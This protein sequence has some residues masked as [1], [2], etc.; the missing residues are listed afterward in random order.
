MII[1]VNSSSLNGV[2]QEVRKLHPFR[3]RASDSIPRSI[4]DEIREK[5]EACPFESLSKLAFTFGVREILACLEILVSNR[6][7]ELGQKAARVL[8]LRPRKQVILRGWFRLVSSYPHD[9]LEATLRELIENKG[10]DILK[11][12]DKVSTQAPYWLVSA[13]LAEGVFREYQNTGE[14]QILDKYLSENLIKS[15]EGL[16]RVVWRQLLT[17][18]SAKSLMKE[19][20]ERILQK[21]SE[22]DNASHVPSFGQHYLN[23]LKSRET[24]DETILDFIEKKFG[25]PLDGPIETPFWQEVSKLAKQDFRTWLILRRIEDFFEGERGDFWRP[26]VEHNRVRRVKEILNRD[27][28]LLDFGAFGVVEFKNVGNAAYIYPRVEF[29]AFW[30]TRPTWN[31]P[32]WFKER[33]KTVRHVSF[34]GWDGRIIHS[35]HWQGNTRAKINR[36]LEV[37]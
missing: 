12:S 3:G 13:K 14:R 32:G 27:G 2:L 29:E 34:P 30:N 25:F 26:Y 16:H 24:W 21:F 36:L 19:S 31:D 17:K 20:P 37:R 9:L 35:G 4:L 11:Q 1:E 7:G 8:R 28:F 18:G 23:T 22:V 6:E 10:F 33:A 5:M 15:E